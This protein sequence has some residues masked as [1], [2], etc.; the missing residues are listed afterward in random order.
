MLVA[1]SKLVAVAGPE[2]VPAA[3]V[4]VLATQEVEVAV[5]GLAAANPRSVAE[6]A[7]SSAAAAA[8]AAAVIAVVVV[9]ALVAVAATVA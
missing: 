6:V 8:A 5:L 4:V 7:A 3:L 9:A 1:D 2:V